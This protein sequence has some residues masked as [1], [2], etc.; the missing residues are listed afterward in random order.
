MGPTTATLGDRVRQRL[1]EA[2]ECASVAHAYLRTPAVRL[3]YGWTVPPA[4]LDI[5]TQLV[6]L[7]TDNRG[8]EFADRTLA[9]PIG[10]HGHLIALLNREELPEEDRLIVE[11]LVSELDAIL[12]E[13]EPGTELGQPESYALAPEAE[14]DPKVVAAAFGALP[15]GSAL[16]FDRDFRYL[17]AGGPELN[18]FGF[19]PR[20]LVGRTIHEVLD[21][22]TRAAVE[23]HYH[24]AFAG[25]DVCFEFAFGNETLLLRFS[26]IKD[27]DGAIV[28]GMVTTQNITVASR[29]KE[30]LGWAR[31]M[32]SASALITGRAIWVREL[33]TQSMFWSANAY[34]LFGR[35]PAQGT[36]SRDEFMARVHE[37][38]QGR[39]AIALETL[40]EGRPRSQVQFRF[41]GFDGRRRHLHTELLIDAR[42]KD[43]PL[44][45]GLSTELEEPL[46]AWALSQEERISILEAQLSDALARLRCTEAP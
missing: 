5:A 20:E 22:A 25:E 35:D 10:P 30:E 18:R 14:A 28:A 3:P 45:C 13:L 16:V 27:G 23:P 34:E 31:D 32:L 4:Y 44:L 43:R 41:L 6:R 42:N 24:A 2:E 8:P 21:P 37:E 38:D 15:S 39:L 19:R 29:A 7:A 36:P 40:R 12:T 17:F 46:D 1:D 9:W 33:D 26:P 11:V